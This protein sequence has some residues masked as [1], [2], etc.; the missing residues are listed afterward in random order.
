[1]KKDIFNS[2][3]MNKVGTN[4]FNLSH[5]RKFSCAMG[6][7]IPILCE[8]LV[9]GDRWKVSSSHL[10]RFAPMIAPVMHQ[11]K[12]HMHFFFV[13]NRLVWDGWED[14]ITGGEKGDKNNVRPYLEV[15]QTFE[16]SLS[17]YLGLPVYNIG[18]TGEEISAIPF[19]AYQLI[20]NEYF[21]D[22]NLQDEVDYK[23]NDGDNTVKAAVLSPLQVR[24]W[25]KDY[26]TSALPWTQK[27]PEA[28]IPLGTSA[29]VTYDDT[30][31][32]STYVKNTLGAINPNMIAGTTRTD[33]SGQLQFEENGPVTSYNIDNSGVLQVDLSNA[34]AATII[35]VRNAFRLQ[36]W[37]EKN[38]RGGNRYIEN[39]KAHFGVNSS[40]ARLQRPEFL[41]GGSA[42]VRISEVLQT[43]ADVTEPTPQGNMAG[44]GISVSGMNPFSYFAE[45][46]GYIIGLMSVCPRPA[47]QQGIPRHFQRLDKFDYFWPEFQHI[48]EQPILNKE[49][50]VDNDGANDE[51]FGYAPRYSEYKYIPDTVHGEFKTSLNF[52]HHGRIFDNR[53]QLNED[54]IKCNPDRRV[55]AVQEGV[56][57][58]YVQ[59]QNRILARRPMAYYG[60]PGFSI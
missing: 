10:L 50:Y 59:V 32:L 3:Q 60:N 51:T 53:P 49:L 39:I 17:D 42:P 46:H 28:T 20:W 34:T 57:S 4:T 11:Y 45:E 1:M 38:A 2:V 12:V 54:F 55:F 29:P 27:G 52:W 23:L 41:G 26:F 22:Q 13:P 18:G 6:R 14:H 30:A 43:S 36:E 21:R 44:H 56:H 24:A 25:T 40:D 16:G 31:G 7:L 47:Y 19:A 5:Q 58:L 33:A 35:D 48:G 8:D 37:L 9:P 15:P